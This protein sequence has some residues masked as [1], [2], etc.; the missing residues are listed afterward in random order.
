MAIPVSSLSRVCRSVA[1]FV[2]V[3]IGAVPHSIRVLIGNPA[4]A[5]KESEES[6]RVNLFFYQL[7]PNGFGP[8]PDPGQTWWIRLHCLITAFAIGEDQI[9]S[10]END[11][12]ILGEVIRAFHETPV[13]GPLDVNG[14]SVRL[15][16]IFVP[17]TL[18]QINHI[19][20]TQGDV[21]FRPS[22]C[23]EMTLVPILPRNRAIEAPRVAALGFEV[24]GDRGLD[25]EPFGGEVRRPTVSRRAV[26]TGRPDWE[27]RIC[28]VLG[29]V[30]QESVTLEVGSPELA[31]FEARVWIAG[32]PGSDVRLR[33]EAWEA[34]SGWTS[35]PGGVDTT[36]TVRALIPEEAAT[37]TTTAAPLPFTDRPV[38]FLLY[39]SR[40]AKRVDGTNVEVRSN[41]LLITLY[42]EDEP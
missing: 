36:A 37:A 2:G 25:R 33:W 40:Q 26:D 42:E 30:C 31:A 12:R 24:R 11:L 8:S 27:P 28:L 21:G 5:S 29:G 4:D 14:I 39:A 18:D 32:E 6:H 7:E 1:D 22:V 20:S 41:P 35:L 23:Y 13:L 34:T 19:W 10:G 15:Q 17:M 9:S 16:A 38:Q 3:Q